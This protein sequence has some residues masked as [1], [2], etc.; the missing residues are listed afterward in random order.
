MESIVLRLVEQFLSPENAGPP[1]VVLVAV[2]DFGRR[3]LFPYSDIDLLFLLA[4]QDTG[5]KYKDAI[6]QFSQGMQDVGLKANIDDKEF[7]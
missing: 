5:D 1:G 7:L 4:T 3:L 6:E 2:G